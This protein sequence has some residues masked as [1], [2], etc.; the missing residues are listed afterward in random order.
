[1][2]RTLLALIRPIKA[3]QAPGEEIGNRIA[4]NRAG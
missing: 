3:L 2:S 1:V 4:C